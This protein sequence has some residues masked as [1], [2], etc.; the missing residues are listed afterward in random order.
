MAKEIERKFIVND[1]CYKAMA[2]VSHHIVQGYLSRRPE[3]TVRIRVK[4][5]DAFVTIK[6]I[7]RGATRD[8]WEYSIPSGDA[9]DMLERCSEGNVIEKT[10]YIV[11]WEG[12]EWE[13]DCF[14]GTLEGLVVAEIE[15]ESE[16]VEF[17]LPPFVSREVTDDP[18]YFNS[19]LC[20]MSMVDASMLRGAL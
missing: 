12:F 16:D 20:G 8:E 9:I 2:T 18:R 13:V 1:P 7:T 11:P 17:P 15:L 10:R 3:A 6:G 19:S 14:H 5:Q 4:D